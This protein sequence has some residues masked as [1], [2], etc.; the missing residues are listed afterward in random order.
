ML[1]TNIM[2]AWW[3]TSYSLKEMIAMD[4]FW[5]QRKAVASGHKDSKKIKHE[6]KKKGMILYMVYC[7]KCST[8]SSAVLLHRMWKLV[9][10]SFTTREEAV[11][12]H[13]KIKAPQ[14]PV[15]GRERKDINHL[16]H[17]SLSG[18]YKALNRPLEDS[19]DPLLFWS[20]HVLSQI[21]KMK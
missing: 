18:A 4:F 10:F 20:I 12:A 2:S 14:A 17:L 13:V 6:Y 8:Y 1:N 7:I 21:D 11:L 9:A 5:L 16:F 19:N 15:S 3:A